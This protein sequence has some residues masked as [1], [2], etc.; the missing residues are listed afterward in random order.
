MPAFVLG[1]GSNGTL[2]M[3]GPVKAR[4]NLADNETVTGVLSKTETEFSNSQG[5]A[6]TLKSITE[7]VSYVT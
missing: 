1:L 6:I 3:R 4:E 7:Y 5:T 2:T